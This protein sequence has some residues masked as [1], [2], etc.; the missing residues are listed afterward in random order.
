[1][2]YGYFKTPY[3]ITII[4]NSPAFLKPKTQA[5]K[6]VCIVAINGEEPI[7]AQV[8][9]MNP[10]YIKLYVENPSLRSVY[11]EVIATRR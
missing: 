10:I 3:A 6:N 1:M 7:A 4:P 11:A 5:L 8:H 9:L 2:D